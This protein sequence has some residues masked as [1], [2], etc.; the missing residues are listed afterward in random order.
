[1]DKIMKLTLCWPCVW[2]CKGLYH[3]H[4]AHKFSRACPG[5]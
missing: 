2:R 5:V 3:F 1:M 4:Y